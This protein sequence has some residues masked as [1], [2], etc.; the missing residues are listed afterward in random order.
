MQPVFPGTGALLF[1][2]TSAIPAHENSYDDQFIVV[3]PALTGR[4][5]FCRFNLK[6]KRLF[7]KNIELFRE[8]LWAWT[9]L[10]LEPPVTRIRPG[11]SPSETGPKRT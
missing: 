2:C 4:P 5:Q 7:S 1:Y 6:L 8:S 9:L 10:P 11:N 3:I